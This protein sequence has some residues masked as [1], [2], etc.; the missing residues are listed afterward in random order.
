MCKP[1][2]RVGPAYPEAPKA[3]TNLTTIAPGPALP[4]NTMYICYTN[5]THTYIMLV[6]KMINTFNT[7]N[8]CLI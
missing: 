2:L 3:P 4:G 7:H 5:M 6:Y 1:P 8:S